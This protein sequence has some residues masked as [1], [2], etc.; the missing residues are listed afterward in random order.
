MIVCNNL[1]HIR[2]AV[3]SRFEKKST[4]NYN[5]EHKTNVNDDG[6]DSGVGSVTD[7]SDNGSSGTVS[8][9]SGGCGGSG[10]NRM[11]AGHSGGDRRNQRF[12]ES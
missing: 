1:Q 2:T 12:R 8:D 5:H 3:T 11:V 6:N 7:Q 4:L 10:T 9:S